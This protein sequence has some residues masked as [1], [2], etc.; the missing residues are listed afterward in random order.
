MLAQALAVKK[1]EFDNVEGN[2][3]T[4][5]QRIKAGALGMVDTRNR[6]LCN[7]KAPFF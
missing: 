2:T 5:S 6:R 4:V 1:S 7:N 3:K